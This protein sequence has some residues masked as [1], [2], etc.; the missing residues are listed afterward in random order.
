[1][2]IS[3]QVDVFPLQRGGARTPYSTYILVEAG[4]QRYNVGTDTPKFCAT[5]LADIPVE[6]NRSA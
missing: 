6:S 3:G 4:T 5:S 1:M 2:I